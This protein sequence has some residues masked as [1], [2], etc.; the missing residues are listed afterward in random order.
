[1]LAV[2]GFVKD[3]CPLQAFALTFVTLFSVVPILFLSLTVVKT[4]GNVDRARDQVKQV[5][6]DWTEGEK[7]VVVPAFVME[8]MPDTERDG[9][10]PV[11][12]DVIGDLVDAGF[13]RFE[14]IKLGGLGIIGVL[15]LMWIALEMLRRM[16]SAFN[17]VWD[18]QVPRPL[19]KRGLHYLGAIVIVTAL[20]ACASSFPIARL[21]SGIVGAET[22]L[23]EF[24]N[25]HGMV[26]SGV[27][28]ALAAGAFTFL[29]KYFPS[30]KVSF[31]AA[32]AG[33]VFIAVVMRFWIKLCIELQIGV[34][35]YNLFFGSFAVLPL[36]LSW[37]YMSWQ[38]VLMGAEF[39]F[40]VQ[41]ASRCRI[42]PMPS[43]SKVV[44]TEEK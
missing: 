38:I 6:H 7:I 4:F 12:T 2:K 24:V 19:W 32:M 15:M 30:A 40:A 9:V 28:L 13:D 25:R 1:H 39:A 26:K 27:S 18:I 16:V 3:E 42:N 8:K 5:I 34:A 23:G 41:H 31:R 17:R 37:V 43:P 36:L 10:E 22:A 35:K 29:L 44:D 14:N 11:T 33:G 20:L 21:L